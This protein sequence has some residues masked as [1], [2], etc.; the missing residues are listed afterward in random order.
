MRHTFQQQLVWET[1][2]ALCHPTAEEVYE[3]AIQVCPSLSRGTVYRHLAAFVEQ[4]RLSK[5]HMEDHSA[6]FDTTR[7]PHY[8][9]VCESCGV[10]FDIALP[11]QN[12]LNDF[13]DQTGAVIKTHTLFF[14]GI[15]HNCQ[16]KKG[17]KQ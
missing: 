16:K 14:H 10:F 11:Y 9:A 1:V 4:R 15:C 5:V 8:H 12:H 2:Q 3:R 17:K 6:R 13:R 7:I